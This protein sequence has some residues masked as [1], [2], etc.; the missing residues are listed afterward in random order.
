M[1]SSGNGFLG[2]IIFILLIMLSPAIILF[3]VGLYKRK[4]KPETAKILFIL[5]A[6]YVLIGAG[7]CGALMSQ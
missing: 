5:S 6:V 2:M 3:L 4:S 1:D 7:I